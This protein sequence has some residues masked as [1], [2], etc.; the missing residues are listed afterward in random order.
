MAATIRLAAPSDAQIIREIYAPYV[1]DTPVSF[2]V[3]IPSADEM[4]KRVSNTLLAL[5]W[6]ICETPDGIAGYAYASQHRARLAYQWSTDVSVY[7][8]R[9]FHRKGIGRALSGSHCPTP[10]VSD[11]TRR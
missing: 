8:H 9:D 1:T 5:P 7:I 11:C 3:E 2:E 4:G 10:G 6:L